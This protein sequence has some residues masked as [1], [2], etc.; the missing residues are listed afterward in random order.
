MMHIHRVTNTAKSAE[1]RT[2]V[3]RLQKVA[4]RAGRMEQM[5]KIGRFICPLDQAECWRHQL[6]A[7]VVGRGMPGNCH[8][9]KELARL[10][11]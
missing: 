1:I 3:C 11:A 5:P 2:I 9:I 7:L 10:H 4:K 8:W 6:E